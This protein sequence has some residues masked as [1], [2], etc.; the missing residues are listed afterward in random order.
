VAVYTQVPA[1]ALAEL[2]AGYAIGEPRSFKGIAEGVEN[3]NYCLDT[4]AGRFILTLYEK[5]VAEEDLPYFFGLTE[6][7]AARGLPAPRPVPDRAGQVL[8]RLCG[9][10]AAIVEFLPGVS[11]SAP[12]P[13]H[14]AAAGAALARLHALSDDFAPRRANAFGPAGWRSLAGR[15]GPAADQIA[16]GLAAAIDEELDDLAG[17]WPA[18]LP[19]GAIHA[20]LF[21]DNVLFLGHQVSGLI[22]FYFAATDLRAYD[23]A[24]MHVAWA[25][26]PSTDQPR[27]DIAAAL[28]DGYRSQ[29]PLSAAERDALPLLARGA[30]LRFLLT[31]AWDWLNT[32]AGALVARKD[33]LSFWRRLRALART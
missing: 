14:A 10:P 32:P 18:D 5:R 29:R 20:D 26:D 6:H 3:S 19:A 31:R 4:T 2:L 16:P 28:I 24:V 11:V 7:L 30:A 23:L 33:P 1:E 13:A 21:P 22:D 17:R 15:V 8:Q 27:P 25:F 9:R 12:A